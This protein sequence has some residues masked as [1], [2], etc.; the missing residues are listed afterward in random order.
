MGSL[1]H[2]FEVPR[3]G[4]LRLSSPILGD[5][6]DSQPFPRPRLRLDRRYAR[7]GALYCLYRVFGAASDPMTGR[8]RV[9]AGF[10]IVSDGKVR[11]R[12]EASLIEPAK[13]G[14][15]L[16]LLAVGLADLPPGPYTLTIHIADAVTGEALDVDEPFS[17]VS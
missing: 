8:P 10:T 5:Q 11:R 14:Q 4:G 15:L 13:D 9:Y 12:I 16:R 7:D 17:V 2:T 6:I 3:P 1:L